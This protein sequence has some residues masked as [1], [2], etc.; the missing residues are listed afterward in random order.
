MFVTWLKSRGCFSA[1]TRHGS[2]VCFRTA[3]WPRDAMNTLWVYCAG[4]K[5]RRVPYL[6]RRQGCRKRNLE[7]IAW[8]VALGLYISLDL[9]SFTAYK[10]AKRVNAFF[11]FHSFR[12]EQ[13][14][15]SVCLRVR[16]NGF[17]VCFFYLFFKLFADA[18]RQS[19][20]KATSANDTRAVSA[21]RQCFF[22]TSQ[23]IDLLHTLVVLPGGLEW[24]FGI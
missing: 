14:L 11:Q 4:L 2:R 12:P 20:Y 9:D 21:E 15:T 8:S 13:L 23:Q 7:F 6:C 3:E 16:T 10:Q 1:G 18:C 24:I 22:F 19:S 17:F 5:L